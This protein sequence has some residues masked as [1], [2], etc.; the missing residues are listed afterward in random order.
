MNKTLTPAYGRDYKSAKAARACFLSGNDWILAD[1]TSRWDGKPC[2]MRDFPPGTKFNLR[3][4][5]LTQ[6]CTVE[7]P[8]RSDEQIVTD[9]LDGLI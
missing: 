8:K 5:R 2:S 9:Q 6:L 1:F 4:K 3:Y 7:V